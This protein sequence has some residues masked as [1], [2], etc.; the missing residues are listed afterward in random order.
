MAIR[1]VSDLLRDGLRIVTREPES[2][3]Q[4]L[5]DRCL[6]IA[7][8]PSNLPGAT[9][10]RANGH[11]DVARLIWARVADVGIA[12][13]DA[14]LAL[15]LAFVPLAVERFDLVF[16]TSLNDDRRLTRLLEELS[17]G[18]YRTDLASLGYEVGSSGAH[19]IDIAA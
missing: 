4:R 3:A 18:G 17:S 10:L 8:I 13:L 11:L 5:L 16:E 2:G 7:G 15:G 6:R 12:T 19:V 1:S 14:A 9:S